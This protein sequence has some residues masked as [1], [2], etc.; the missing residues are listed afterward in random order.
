[1]RRGRYSSQANPS[2]STTIR[3]ES[4]NPFTLKTYILDKLKSER[5]NSVCSDNCFMSCGFISGNGF[6]SLKDGN[7]NGQMLS[8]GMNEHNKISPFTFSSV[9]HYLFS[10]KGYN[11]TWIRPSKHL[12]IE[13]FAVLPFGHTF[14]LRSGQ[15]TTCA[16]YDMAQR[17]PFLNHNKLTTNTSADL[18]IFTR[19]CEAS[20]RDCPYSADIETLVGTLLR[21]IEKFVDLDTYTD[22]KK[23]TSLQRRPH[24]RQNHV[25]QYLK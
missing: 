20:E 9:D 13:P 4:G 12:N 16:Q 19:L 7:C 6:Q 25:K 23:L 22:E 3:K 10:Q 24:V 15:N 17:K 21:Q 11:N 14:F 18:P 2:S 5:S 1:M 8:K